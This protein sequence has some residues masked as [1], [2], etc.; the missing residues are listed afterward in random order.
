MIIAGL[1][2]MLIKPTLFKCVKI[3]ETQSSD[4]E[5]GEGDALVHDT[6]L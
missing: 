2:V 4:I 5:G 6:D 3:N 1:I